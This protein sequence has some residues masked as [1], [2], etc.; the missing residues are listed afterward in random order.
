MQ[1]RKLVTN[2]TQNTPESASNMGKIGDT[3]R[4]RLILVNQGV[5]PAKD[6]K[7]FDATPAYTVLTVAPS[8]TVLGN[9]T[10]NL[11]TP[12]TVT[13]SYSGPLEWNCPGSFPPGQSGSLTFDVVI[14]P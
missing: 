3:L 13:A 5:T 11:V 1:L 10:C 9:V 8:V 2:V 12:S 14:A 7:V 4:Y 6:V